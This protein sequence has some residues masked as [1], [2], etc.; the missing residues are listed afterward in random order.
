M[1]FEGIVILAVN[2]VEVQKIKTNL[3][4]LYM[5]TYFSKT[6][7]FRRPYILP[8]HTRSLSLPHQ[9]YPT[10]DSVG[11]MADMMAIATV[12]AF[13]LQ[14]ASKLILL[15]SILSPSNK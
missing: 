6:I 7:I 2:Y 1:N 4:K 11:M 10:S 8:T 5:K 12:R 13:T 15:S 3:E 9:F 14:S